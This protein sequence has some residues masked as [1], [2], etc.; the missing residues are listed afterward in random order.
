MTPP[1][2]DLWWDTVETVLEPARALLWWSL[3]FTGH[4][5]DEL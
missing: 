1:W 2:I 3:G 5:N 4:E